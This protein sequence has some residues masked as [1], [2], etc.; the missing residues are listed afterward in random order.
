MS[1]SRS[2]RGVTPLLAAA[3]AAGMLGCAVDAHEN[4]AAAET[5]DAVIIDESGNG[6]TFQAV[7]GQLV[8]VRLQANPMAGYRWV[9]AAVDRSFGSPVSDEMELETPPDGAMGQGG[10]QILTWQ[11]TGFLPLV[12][13]HAVT[14]EYRRIGEE[15]V[16][17]LRTF[18]FTVDIT[19]AT[20]GE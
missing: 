10:T 20:A 3:L 17:A 1:F 18:A 16:P 13:E 5:T 12:G 15:D 8:V 7:E 14:L 9:V 19:S 11:T 2:L 4:G 6:G